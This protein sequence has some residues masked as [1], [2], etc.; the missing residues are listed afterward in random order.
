MTS[1]GI[2]IR[3]ALS[4]ERTLM[5]KTT[6][7]VPVAELVRL[8]AVTRQAELSVDRS[9]RADWAEFRSFY[10]QASRVEHLRSALHST[11]RLDSQLDHPR[12]WIEPI[13]ALLRLL[14]RLLRRHR[15][16][17]SLSKRQV[18]P[19]AKTLETLFQVLSQ[20]EKPPTDELITLRMQLTACQ[21]MLTSSMPYNRKIEAAIESVEHFGSAS[22]IE[23]YPLDQILGAAAKVFSRP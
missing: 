15:S 12:G 5:A 10:D 22:F 6:A 21:A 4:G 3:P 17:A 20:R 19:L 8:A 23:T 11:T 7:S 1:S 18:N 9:L 2:W 16:M 14:K 13:R